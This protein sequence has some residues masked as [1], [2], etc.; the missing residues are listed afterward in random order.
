MHEAL[1]K[2]TAEKECGLIEDPQAGGYVFLSDAVKPIRDKRGGY[3]PTS[4]EC[5]RAKIY[6]LKQGVADHPLFRIQPTARLENIKE[7]RAAVK[8]GRNPFIGGA[9]DVELQLEF[10]EPPLWDEK[11][12]EYLLSSNSQVELKN[13]VILLAK[14]DDTIDDFLPEIVRSEKIEMIGGVDERSA[15]HVVAQY[16]RAERRSAERYRERVASIM[17][18]VFLD[19]VFI[20]RGKPTPVREAGETL[21]A[22]VRNI[23]SSAVKEIFPHFHLAPIRPAMDIAAKFLAVERMDRIGKDLDPLGLVIKSRGAPRIDT[24]SPVLAEA[25]RVF[26]AK[27]AESGSGRLQGSYLHDLFSSP[28]YG[29]TKDT[30]RYL[31]AALLRAGEI[32]F[33]VPGAGAPV[34]TAG[35]QAVEAKKSTV[36]FNKIGISLREAKLPT[37]ALDR[38]AR[39]LETLFGDEVLPLEDHISRSVRHHVPDLLEIIGA[40]PD[41]LRLLGLAG[42]DRAKALHADAAALLKGDAG[43]AAAILG[44]VDCALPD[45]I[46][47]SKA[48]FDALESGAEDDVRKAKLVLDSLGELESIFPGATSELLDD[49]DRAAAAEILSSDR[50]HERLPDLRSIVGGAF[51]RTQNRYSEEYA[52]YKDSLR[53]ALDTL[54]ADP[55]WLRLSDEDRQDLGGN[56]VCDLPEKAADDDCLR[57]LNS[58]LVK[59]GTLP[60]LLEN[61]RSEIKRRKP[62]GPKPDKD[63]ESVDEEVVEA[64]ALVQSALITTTEDLESWLSFIRD[65]LTSILKS[66]KRIRIKGR[67]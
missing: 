38:A 47:W 27:A 2:L 9:E 43:E 53:K 55:D 46:T 28:Q 56:L 37:E 29:W 36:A 3:A 65:K 18:K 10:V 13:T 17:V 49:D 7:V 62:Q 58:L 39:R 67:E 48:V 19:G 11:R 51:S 40:L 42:M 45:E 14:N 54:E 64:D 4:G 24:S 22:A 63:G 6:I 33:H 66:K 32:E 15:D 50:F 26:K 57:L 52:A 8:L 35:P 1:R 34:R 30:V 5:I 60:G 31:F 16:L 12:K 44:G 23:L 25:M 61:L 20:F 59:K 41:R 21:D